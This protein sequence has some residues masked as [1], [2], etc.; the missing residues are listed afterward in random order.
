MSNNY[1]RYNRPNTSTPGFL[2]QSTKI[3]KV[4]PVRYR[5]E[6]AYMDEVDEYFDFLEE[7]E[8]RKKAIEE[9]G[10]LEAQ[11]EDR[12]EVQEV[13]ESKYSALKHVQ[14]KPC[15]IHVDGKPKEKAD[16]NASS[17]RDNSRSTQTECKLAGGTLD[18]ICSKDS[19]YADSKL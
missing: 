5:N 15:K 10:R 12:T 8:M 19:G 1:T 3:M 11:E 17:G 4:D 16:N 6:W 2:A 14:T 9:G 7:E 18:N 13:Y